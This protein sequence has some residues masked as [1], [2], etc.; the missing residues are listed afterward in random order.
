MC[1]KG[2]KMHV[3]HIP[4]PGTTVDQAFIDT[5]KYYRCGR[6]DSSISISLCI[7]F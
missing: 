4:P 6:E 5:S 1:I 2:M 3:I 7:P